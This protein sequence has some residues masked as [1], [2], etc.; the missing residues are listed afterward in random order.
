[1]TPTPP[2]VPDT[3]S[4][5]EAAQRLGMAVRSVQLMVDR[6]ELTAWKTPGGHRR[7]LRSSLESWL[8]SRGSS[9]PAPA[10]PQPAARSAGR[11][12]TLLLIEDS[13]HFQN[14]ISLIVKRELP[15]AE[16]HVASDGIAGLAL[17]GRLEPDV[18]LID[19]LLPGIDGAALITSLRSHPQFARSRLIVVTALDEAQREPYRFALEGVPVVHKTALVGQLP[20]L[21]AEAAALA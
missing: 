18:L 19:I 9:G 20:P 1:M 11:P 14:L 17:A 4:T 8:A 12:M 16:L 2:A 6:G 5:T 15:G 3:C 21:L 13:V 10:A 7:I